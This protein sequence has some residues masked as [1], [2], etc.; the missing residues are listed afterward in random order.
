MVVR[1]SSSRVVTRPAR[2]Y[3]EFVHIESTEG[4]VATKN[5]HGILFYILPY[6]RKQ[7]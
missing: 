7:H 3:I 4:G 6:I 5:Y 1:A 2:D